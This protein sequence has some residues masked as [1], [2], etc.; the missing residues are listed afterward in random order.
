VV[1]HELR[2]PLAAVQ[3]MLHLL[4]DQKRLSAAGRRALELIGQSVELEAQLIDDLLDVSRIVHGKLALKRAWVDV[5][6][7]V[8]QALEVS[9]PDFTVKALQLSV[10]LGAAP[11]QVWGDGARLRQ[12]FWNL[13]KNAAKFTPRGGQ[14]AVRSGNL[15]TEAGEPKIVLE[16]A[17]SGIGIEPG[18]LAKIFAPFDQGGAGV[19]RRYGGLGLGLAIC[20]AIVAAH[21]GRLTAVS[22]GPGRGAAFTVELS[23]SETPGGDLNAAEEGQPEST[24]T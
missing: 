20:Q 11:S 8:R 4:R 22:A 10:T 12:V 18:A 15:M 23:L 21:R 3:M 7:C 16:V 14:V 24:H 19:A 5:H 9:R 17:D 2:T 13:F 6:D 1:S